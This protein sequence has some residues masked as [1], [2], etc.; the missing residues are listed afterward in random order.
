MQACQPPS[1]R[2]LK[3]TLLLGWALMMPPSTWLWWGCRVDWDYDA[4]IEKWAAINHSA[5]KEECEAVHAE[6][7]RREAAHH[8]RDVAL[9]KE[10]EPWWGSMF[11][12]LIADAST[13]A[14]CIAMADQWTHMRRREVPDEATAPSSP[15]NL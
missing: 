12:P 5:T 1:L 3:A 8:D 13:S 11:G 14:V 6:A 4:P 2:L 10:K 7:A 15:P 9:A